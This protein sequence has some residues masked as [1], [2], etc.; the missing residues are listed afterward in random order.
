MDEQADRSRLLFPRH[1]SRLENRSRESFASCAT[2]IAQ[3][4]SLT[5]KA[6]LRMSAPD[7]RERV[8]ILFA[9]NIFG[10]NR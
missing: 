5:V 4:Q 9:W 1:S 6:A 2:N 10:G 3:G 7:A 8:N